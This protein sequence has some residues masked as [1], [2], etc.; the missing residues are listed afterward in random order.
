MGRGAQG[1]RKTQCIVD[2][3]ESLELRSR[4]VLEQLVAKE[5]AVTLYCGAQLLSERVGERRLLLRGSLLAASNRRVLCPL[6]DVHL[7]VVAAFKLVQVA[8]V[9]LLVIVE[10]QRR[11]RRKRHCLLYVIGRRHFLK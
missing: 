9:L 11:L 3:E 7:C 1:R 5:A 6:I 8:V 10:A 2:F 4:S